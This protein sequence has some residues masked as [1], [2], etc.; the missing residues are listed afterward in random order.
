MSGWLGGVEI[1]GL[2]VAAGILALVML[3]TRRRW[4]SR[5]G[6][7]FE[8]SLRMVNSVPGAGWALGV[9][10]YNQGLLE[11]FRFFSF[12]VR[13]KQTFTRAEVRVLDSRDPDPVEAVSLTSDQRI[14]RLQVTGAGP[15][16]VER[17][18]AMTQDSLTGLLAWLEAAPPGLV[19][20]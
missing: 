4:L 8:C 2:V 5:Q 1:L 3:A 17:D 15:T 7:T 18:L 14:I 20:R 11:W 9:G 13:P 19:S 16:A 6:G 10:R 12:S